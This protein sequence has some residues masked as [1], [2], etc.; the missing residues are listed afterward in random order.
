MDMPE[1][2]PPIWANKGEAV[3]C[4]NGHAICEI[5]RNI[6]EATKDYWEK[7]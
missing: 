5:A 1:H 7:P 6:Y 2:G 4:I 3:T